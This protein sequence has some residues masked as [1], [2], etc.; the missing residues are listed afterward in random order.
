[1][2]KIKTFDTFFWWSAAAFLSVVALI[3]FFPAWFTSSFSKYNFTTTGQIGDTIGGIMGP[4]IA[5][6]ASALTFLA[7]W[8]Q[9]KANE[10]Q[11]QDIKELKLRAELEQFETKFLEMVRFHRDNVSE[12]KYTYYE[13]AKDGITAQSRK[14]FKVLYT[15]FL[16]LFDEINFF[17]ESKN[18]DEI[19]NSEYLKKLKQNITLSKSDF[20]YLNYAQIDITYCIFYFGVKEEEQNTIK[21]FL[22]K[23]YDSTFIESVIFFTALKPARNIA[24][25]YSKWKS[26]IKEEANFKITYLK[27][28]KLDWLKDVTSNGSIVSIQRSKTEEDSKYCSYYY[29]KN[30]KKYYRGHQVRLGNYFRQL[31]QTVSF[32]NENERISYKL[33]Y[34]YVKILR[35]QLSAYEQSLLFINSLSVLGRVWELE[36]NNNE[37]LEVN[38]QLITKYNL[39]KNILS[40]KVNSK[41]TISEFYPDIEY[42]LIFLQDVK[43]KRENLQKEYWDKYE[44]KMKESKINNE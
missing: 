22:S 18:E 13:D 28:F 44:E 1:M 2:K 21:D 25:S 43:V 29:P 11:K 32:V 6:A 26:Y 40:D 15:D 4:F 24:H 38:K 42:E 5:I 39:I 35:G 3:C 30:F 36:W 37:L 17:F 10:Q 20:S 31:Y 23:R 14:V 34:S 41:I 12:L 19:Y 16:Y 8:V 33:K 7:F 9:Y 27:N